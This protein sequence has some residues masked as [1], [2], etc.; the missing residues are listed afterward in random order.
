VFHVVPN[1][2]AKPSTLAFSPRSWPMAHQ[3]ALVVSNARGAAIWSF[4]SV[5]T[6][7]AHAGSTHRQVRLRQTNCT[8][9]PKHGASINSTSRRPWLWAITPQERQPI[10]ACT[11]STRTLRFPTSGTNSTPVT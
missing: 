5:K 4:C 3:H 10:T 6:L 8:G 1:C 9:R 11:D 2:R 7:T